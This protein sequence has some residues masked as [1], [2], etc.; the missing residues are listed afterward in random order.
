MSPFDIEIADEASM[1]R[2]GYDIAA[3]L[4]PG[5][6]IGLVGDLGA[7]KSTLARAIIRA[8]ADDPDLEVPSPTFTLVQPYE[9][10]VRIVHADL[11]RINDP[12]EVDELGLGDPDAAEIVEWPKTPLPITLSI[13]FA[14]NESARHLTVT[15]PDDFAARLTR[16]FAMSHFIAGAGWGA[17]KRRPLKQDASTRSY[18]RLFGA[19]RNAVLMN[20]P[21]F[22]PAPDSYLALARLADGNNNAFLAIGALL[23]SRGL[24][25]PKVLAADPQGGFILLEDL[26]DAKIAE[27]G[28]P[29][30][31][32]YEVA[33]DVLAHFHQ[34]PPPQPIPGPEG[35]HAA[36]RFDTT[37]AMREVVL[38]PQW[39]L[40][41]ET[42]AEYQ[43]LWQDVL[44]GL[45]RGD[46]HLALRDYHS[47]NC[48]WLPQR[49]G[50]ARIGIIDYQDAMIAPSAYDVASLAQDARVPVPPALEERLV[51]RYL[52]ARPGLDT[53]RWRTAYHIVGAQ[54]ATRIAGLFRRLNDRDGKPQYL[55]HIPHVLAALRRNL[56]ATP[57]LAPL[58]DWFS[59]NSPIMDDQ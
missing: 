52:A 44:G 29:I 16:R 24:S 3:I 42:T 31:E 34:S 45:W 12:T 19:N 41:T 46:D 13:E 11:Y 8:M 7:G 53:A 43:A 15:A 25:S 14:D 37:L 49:Q 54:R 56:R 20:A 22:T 21:S 39:F 57:A 1:A 55:A 18:E 40:R 32:R 51:A 50:V 48:L 35:P 5:D 6:H 58:A 4:R 17:A 33:V 47:P 38:F 9:G 23:A 27:D 30:V 26:G 36:P 2:L 10:R 28:A 59:R